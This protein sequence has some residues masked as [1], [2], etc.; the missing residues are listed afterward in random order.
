MTRRP[1]TEQ[2]VAF[3]RDNYRTHT[4]KW[5]GRKIERTTPCVLQKAAAVGLRKTRCPRGAWRTEIVEFLR[6]ALAEGLLDTEIA[7]RWNALGK[8][9]VDRRTVCYYRRRA[10]LDIGDAVVLR[11]LD[12]KRDA[13]RTQ[14]QVLQVRS[15]GDLQRRKVRRAAA[16]AGWP[17]NCSVFECRLLGLL[18]DGRP[19][20][21]RELAE[22]LADPA[23]T[24]AYD[25]HK[26]L[27]TSSGC[28]SV[29]GNLVRRGLVVKSAGRPIRGQGKGHSLFTYRLSQRAAEH[30]ARCTRRRIA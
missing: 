14:L 20:T 27:Q 18:A 25:S 10:G 19:R 4:A 30:H 2:D 16:A 1:W 11:R 3:L 7:E 9:P 8:W 13:L 15:F 17:L 24:A 22:A 12:V 29:L 6:T 21:R 28:G 23:R 26:A 5:I